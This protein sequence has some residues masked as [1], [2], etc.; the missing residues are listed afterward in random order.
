[1]ETRGVLELEL[2]NNEL[3]IMLAF[4]DEHD[5]MGLSENSCY[6]EKINYL[7]DYRVKVKM[8]RMSDDL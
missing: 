2:M 7:N 4:K 6:Y 5:I 1:M 8:Y 3:K